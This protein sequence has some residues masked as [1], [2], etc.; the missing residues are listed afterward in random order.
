MSGFTTS[1]HWWAIY[2]HT[3]E[4]GAI[5]KV[6]SR[7]GFGEAPP[8]ADGIVAAYA[9]CTVSSRQRR[10]L[11]RCSNCHRMVHARRPWLT[12]DELKGIIHLNG[13]LPSNVALRRLSL[14]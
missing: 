5:R 4:L 3:P 7:E 11:I 2:E 10:T 14:D 13:S 8:P 1:G 6:A 12:V 9:T